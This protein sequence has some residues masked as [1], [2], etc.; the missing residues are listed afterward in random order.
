MASALSQAG[1][2]VEPSEFA[3]LTMDVQ[4]T[5][6]WTQ[7]SPLR[8]AD[9][10]YLYRKFYSASRFDSIIDGINRE[11]TAKLTLARR[12]GSS[13]YNSNTFPAGNSFYPFKWVQNQQ[14]IIRLLY[15]GR[16]GVIYDATAGQKTALIT[17]SVSA[18]KARFLGVGTT[19]YIGD[20]YETKKII[21][22]GLAWAATT[23]FSLDQFIVDTNGNLQLALGAQTATITAIQILSNVCT[24]FFSSAAGIDIPKNT[25]LTFAGLTVV[26]A[27]NGTTQ[28]ATTV[29]GST[30]ISFAFTNPNVSFSVETGTATTGTGITAGVQPTWATSVGAIT[31]DGGLQWECRGSSVQNWGGAGPTIAPTV[32]QAPAPSIYPAWAASTWYSPLF[33]IFDAANHMQQLTVAGTTGSGTPTWNHSGGTTTDGTCTWQDLGLGAWAALTSYA[34]GTILSVSFTY[35]ITVPEYDDYGNYIGSYQQAV[36]TDSLIQCTTAGTSGSFQPAWSNGGGTTTQDGSAIWTTRISWNPGSAPAWPGATQKA[37]LA[38]QILDANNNI[39][40]VQSYGESGGSA[41]AWAGQS[42][43][44]VDGV[45][46]LVWLNIGPFGKANTGAWKWAFSGLNTITGEITNPSPISNSIIV[47]AGKQAVLQGNG[48]L[49]SQFDT[50]ILWRTAQAGSSLLYEDQFPNPGAGTWIYTDTTPDNLLIAQEA[51]PGS[52]L[53]SSLCTPP[54][55][56]ATAPEYHCG[57]IFLIDGSYVRYSG[58]PDTTV[59]NGNSAFPPLNYFQLPEQPIRLKS[60]TVSGGGLI[61]MCVANTYIILGDGTDAS[62]FLP[63]RMYME[64]A[65][66]M[67][68]DAMC[69]R[70]TTIYGLSNKL[71]GFSFDPANGEVEIGFPIGDQFKQVTTGGITSTLYSPSSAYVTWHEKTSGDTGLYFADGAVGWFRW[72]PTA[73]PESGSLWSPR[74][75]IYNGTSAVQSVETAPGVFNLLIAPASS[76]TIRMRDTSVNADWDDV[77]GVYQGYAS[78]DV[79]GSIGLCET[80]EVAEIAHISLKSVAVGSRPIVSLLID[81]IAAGVTV[82]GRSSAWDTLSLDDGHHEDPPNLEPSITMFSDRYKASSTAKTPKCENFLLKIDYGTQQVADELLKFS[83]FGAVYKER[84]QQ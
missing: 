26:T 78:W 16:D 12:A 40:S 6:I 82:E 64:G 21:R 58:G 28:A 22:S 81:E 53:V 14:E 18:A 15:D 35:Y 55:S 34:L 10:P 47:S 31:Q 75:A 41:P 23:P 9:V 4:F 51:A 66:I 8:D 30:Q 27:L 3:P 17:K 71:K 84:R 70:G 61:V 2:T 38:T 7:R 45:N 73:P 56:T 29:I 36:T 13:V 83:V 54:P 20:G 48:L 59:G 46:G 42:S 80:G 68:Y 69:M 24:V 52:I 1:A 60:V 63:P 57:R 72:S 49:D 43:Y 79:K 76:G 67:N 77:N 62:P 25:N 5:G 19:C 32:T 74:A 50:L 44:T 37:S 39:E 33:V 65:G 11:I